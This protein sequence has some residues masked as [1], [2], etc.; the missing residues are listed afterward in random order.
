MG[1]AAVHAIADHTDCNPADD[2]GLSAQLLEDLGAT[3]PLPAR[4]LP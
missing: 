1:L 3:M 4:P 2:P